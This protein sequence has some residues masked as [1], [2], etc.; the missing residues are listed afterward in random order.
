MRQ[1]F[2]ARK[3]STRGVSS[4]VESPPPEILS[5]PSSS[6]QNLPRRRKMVLLNCAFIREGSVISIIIEEWKTVALLKK[7]IK[8]EKPDTIKGEADK[9]QL[10]LAKKGGA[11]L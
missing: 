1:F 8:E 9:L 5:L 7:A 2:T 6:F 3:S 10:S 11:W 4:L